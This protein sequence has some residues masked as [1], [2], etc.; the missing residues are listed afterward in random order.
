MADQRKPGLARSLGAF[1]GHIWRGVKTSPEEAN[2]QEVRRDVQ[3]H[4][5]QTDKGAVVARRTIIEEVEFRPRA[6]GDQDQR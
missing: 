2:R 3:E 5:E 4:V 6:E 1:V